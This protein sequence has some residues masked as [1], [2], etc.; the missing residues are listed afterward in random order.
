M[1]QETVAEISKSLG[2]L[3]NGRL[4]VQIRRNRLAATNRVNCHNSQLAKQ[5]IKAMLA[6]FVDHE[7]LRRERWDFWL[8][9]SL[10]WSR[11]GSQVN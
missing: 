4:I 7:I 6:R 8:G 9:L 5:P 1:R 2:V 3:I 11:D 10:D